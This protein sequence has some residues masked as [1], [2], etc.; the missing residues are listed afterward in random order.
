MPRFSETLLDY[1]RYPRNLASDDSATVK[2]QADL[3][4]QPPT[5]EIFLRIEDE[6][7]VRASFQAAGCGVTIAAASALTELLAGQSIVACR[8]IGVDDV[9]AVLEGIP[10]DKRFCVDVAI[11]ALKDALSHCGE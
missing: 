11:A 4:G 10:G 6:Q 7:I 9:I 1:A 8:S 5:V 3:D 2:G